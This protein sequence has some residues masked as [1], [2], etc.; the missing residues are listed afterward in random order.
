MVSGNWRMP[1]ASLVRRERFPEGRISGPKCEFAPDVAFEIN[2]PGDTP[3]HIQHKRKDYQ[4]S[5]VIQVWI[6]L[7]KRL[8]ELIYPDRPL[9][10]FEESQPLIIDKLPGFALDLKTLFSV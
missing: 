3:S 6:D 2:S 8:V 7:D 1:D 9:Q 4:E 10:Y 5:G